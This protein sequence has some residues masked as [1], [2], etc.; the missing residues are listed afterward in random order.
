[1]HIGEYDLNPPLTGLWPFDGLPDRVE[2]EDKIFER[3]RFFTYA[4]PGIV[5][6]YRSIEGKNS[7]HLHVTADGTWYIDHVDEWNPD[8][9]WVLE[10][11]FADTHAGKRVKSVVLIAGV[12]GAIGFVVARIAK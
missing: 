6:E 1:M 2:L 7:D 5:A 11:F 3:S 8:R 10:S 9:G 12:L 4:K